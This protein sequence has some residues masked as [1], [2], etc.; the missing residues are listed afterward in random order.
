MA[1]FY[2]VVRYSKRHEPKNEKWL[3]AMEYAR[4]ACNM[5]L[6]DE[7][8]FVEVYIVQECERMVSRLE[9]FIELDNIEVRSGWN[10]EAPMVDING[11]LLVDFRGE[12]ISGALDFVAKIR[13][14]ENVIEIQDF[15]TRIEDCNKRLYPVLVVEEGVLRDR[16][17]G[18]MA[19]ELRQRSGFYVMKASCRWSVL[20]VF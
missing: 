9:E 6:L 5:T 7:K 1:D 14:F 18:L 19:E 13:E 16:V 17:R 3:E 4:D 10:S 2:E 8:Q 12:K 15:I 11:G 20:M